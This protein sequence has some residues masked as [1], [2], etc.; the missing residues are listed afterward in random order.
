M[1]GGCD[2]KTCE[3]GLGSNE[4]KVSLRC[5]DGALE[6]GRDLD[7]ETICDRLRGKGF[8]WGVF[9]FRLQ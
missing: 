8:F 3:L 4:S 1:R 7:G 2:E 5:S 9:F 6:N